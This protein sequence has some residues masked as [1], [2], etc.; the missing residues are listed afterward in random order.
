MAI[1]EANKE[2]VTVERILN[3]SFDKENNLILTESVGFDGKTLT[4]TNASNLALKIER[5][6]SGNPIYIGLASPGTT[7]SESFW[8]IKKLTFNG[9]NDV[10]DIEYADGNPNFDNVWNDR[11]SLTYI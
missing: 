2:S 7:A 4:R 3:N 11:A 5:D 8:Q 9:S 1:N 10:T 6:G